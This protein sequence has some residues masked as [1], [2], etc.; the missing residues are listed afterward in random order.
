MEQ[1]FDSSQYELGAD[2]MHILIVREGFTEEQAA[3][4]ASTKFNLTPKQLLDYWYKD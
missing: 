4:E 2:Y 3:E 1:E